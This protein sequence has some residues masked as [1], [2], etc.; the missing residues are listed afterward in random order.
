MSKVKDFISLTDFTSEELKSF[1]VLAEEMKKKPDDFREVLKGKSLGLIFNKHSTRTRI[2]FQVGIYQLGGTGLF[3]G[4]NQLQISRGESIS[5]TAQVLSRYLDGIMIRT[6]NHDD[7]V[8]LAQNATIPIINGLTDYNHPCQVMADLQTIKEKFGKLEGLKLAYLG[9]GNNMAVSLLNGCVKMGMDI[10]IISPEA[11]TLSAK[12]LELIRP[13]AEEKKINV[14]VTDNVEEGVSGADVIY[15]D[16]WASMGQE[17]E[18]IKRANDFAAYKV[19][20]KIMSIA[21]K[22]AIFLHCL[23]AYRGLEVDASVID[24]PQSMVFD[25]AENRLH[26]QKAILYTLMK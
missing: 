23:P 11:Y 20:D 9:D 12:A 7:I 26:A 2:S 1:L 21:N 8:A 22:G 4:P 13:E 24:G 6:F 19:S 16:V 17:E 18:K 15:T 14:N 10:S 3:F 5:D 25:E